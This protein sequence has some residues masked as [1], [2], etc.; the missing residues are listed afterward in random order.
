MPQAAGR[1]WPAAYGT[2]L[3]EREFHYAKRTDLGLT[4]GTIGSAAIHP[5]YA[6]LTN[7][8]PVALARLLRD[9]PWQTLP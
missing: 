1:P 9:A 7:V 6:D 5:I 4:E 2:S 8:S 3:Q